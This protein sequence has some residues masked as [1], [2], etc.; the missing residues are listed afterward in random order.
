MHIHCQ[1]QRQRQQQRNYVNTAFPARHLPHESGS[2]LKAS[3]SIHSVDVRCN[4]CATSSQISLLPA[5]VAN[6]KLLPPASAEACT[7]QSSRSSG[8]Y[9]LP[10]MRIMDPIGTMAS[11]QP[12][13]AVACIY[14]SP[15]FVYRNRHEL[16]T[17]WSSEN[18]WAHNGYA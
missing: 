11:W 15:W 2:N 3:T 10:I 7:L 16:V 13:P 14:E 18:A 6:S 12:R 5:D 4:M 8:A 9:D 1:Q 17:L